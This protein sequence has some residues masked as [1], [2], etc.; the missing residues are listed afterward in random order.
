MFES[1]GL[2]E[3]LR[4]QIVRGVAWLLFA[5]GAILA[6]ILLGRWSLEQLKHDD[7]FQTSFENIQSDSPPGMKIDDFLAEVRYLARLPRR[8]SVADPESLVRLREAFG[9]HPWVL[10]VDE[11]QTR[12]TT[13]QVRLTF[14]RPALAVDWNGVRRVVDDRG[15]LLPERTAVDGLPVFEGRPQQPPGEAGQPWPDPEVVRQATD[16]AKG[17]KSS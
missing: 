17:R 13:I 5:V 12:S 7:R 8:V 4:R 3:R 14:R 9:R 6:V 15:I 11:I 1:P 2:Y 16:L 10:S